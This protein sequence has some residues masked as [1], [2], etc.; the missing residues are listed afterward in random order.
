M[1]SS[2]TGHV[3]NVQRNYIQNVILIRA[4]DKLYEN[5]INLIVRNTT[6]LREKPVGAA[7][8]YQH[9]LW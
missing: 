7:G 9:F 2:V 8:H 5:R 4:R 6:A 1:R 3:L